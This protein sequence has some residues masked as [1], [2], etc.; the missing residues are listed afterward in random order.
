M[1]IS[2]NTN[3]TEKAWWLGKK[4][5]KK[6]LLGWINWLLTRCG[7]N[8]PHVQNKGVKNWLFYTQNPVIHRGLQFTVTLILPGRILSQTPLL[9]RLQSTLC[10]LIFSLG[11]LPPSSAVLSY[12][13]MSVYAQA[14]RHTHSLWLHVHNLSHYFCLFQHLKTILL[15][16]VRRKCN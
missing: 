15:V 11:E 4:K 1:L 2:N 13:H 7:T 6:G 8:T 5:K 3:K 10:H 14:N 12:P 16:G 9:G